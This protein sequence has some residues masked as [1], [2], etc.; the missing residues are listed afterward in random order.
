M[1][2]ADAGLVA[3]ELD[4]PSAGRVHNG[5]PARQCLDHR[6]RAR[7]LYFRMQEQMRAAVD[8]RRVALRVSS[9]ELDALS[10]AELSEQSLGGRNNATSHDQPR[11]RQM[12]KRP[13]RDFEPIRLSLV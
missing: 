9:D 10:Q 12:R 7:I 1:L 8:I 5:E 13:Q 4:C 11:F 3:D 6:A 2:H